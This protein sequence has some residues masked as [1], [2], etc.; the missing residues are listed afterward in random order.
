MDKPIGAYMK[1]FEE[2]GVDILQE[3]DGELT[4]G[5]PARAKNGMISEELAAKFSKIINLHVTNG[6]SESGAVKVK[7]IVR[8]EASEGANCSN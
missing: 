3:D 4:I 1:E 7:Y 8:A 6:R 5:V 2:L